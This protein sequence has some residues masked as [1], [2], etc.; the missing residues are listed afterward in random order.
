MMRY[1]W[2]RFGNPLNKA[3][4]KPSLRFL[5]ACNAL[6]AGY[7]VKNHDFKTYE[8][9]EYIKQRVVDKGLTM[10]ELARR[11]GLSRQSLYALLDGVTGQVKIATVVALAA[12][13]E[14]HPVV[15]FRLLLS[16]LDF[17]K[18]S[19]A[20]AKYRFDA[21]GFVQD[22]TIPDNSIVT[23][24]SVFIKEW[25]IQ[26]VGHVDWRGRKLICMDRK[27]DAVVL[28]DCIDE[29]NVVR[30]L[31]P[32]RRVIDIPETLTGDSVILTVEFTAPSYPCSVV[33]YWKMVDEIGDICFPATA[34][35]WCLV[36]V[37]SL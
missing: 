27:E 14:V 34:G 5:Q 2:Q 30:G 7:T 29:P 36:K 35:L 16:Q 6:T 18:F 24:D 25:E 28:P 15:L 1:L 26:N 4:T 9:S 20:A 19:T 32:T 37:V 31:I 21:S 12:G 33:S 8:F 23:T 11:T 3:K 22:V 13:L 10:A 17:P